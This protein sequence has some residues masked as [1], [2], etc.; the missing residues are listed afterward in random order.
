MEPT[1]TGNAPL[2]VE[3]TARGLRLVGEV[4]ACTIELMTSALDSVANSG[5]D[6]DLDL[7]ELSFIDI[8]GVTELVRLAERLDGRRLTVYDP[9]ATMCRILAVAWRD[10]PIDKLKVVP[11]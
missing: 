5:G 2:R 1:A 6:V 4:D 10:A 3:P 7:S 9:P 8:A 11:Q